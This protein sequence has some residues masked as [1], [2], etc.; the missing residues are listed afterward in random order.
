M[1]E[2]ILA[3]FLLAGTGGGAMIVSGHGTDLKDAITGAVPADIRSAT[4]DVRSYIPSDKPEQ[5]GLDTAAERSDA[6]R[7]RATTMAIGHTD[8]TGVSLR[9]DC[10]DDARIAG[11]LPEGTVVSV[12]ERGSGLCAEWSLVAAE[13]V[14][15]WV[16]NRYLIAM[17]AADPEKNGAGAPDK[18]DSDHADDESKGGEPEDKSDGNRRDEGRANSAIELPGQ[19]AGTDAD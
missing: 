9:S 18:L 1:K 8:G 4:E 10:A 14:S 3:M 12:T 16:R 13:G 11:S 6:G 17:P 5:P 15:T 19:P 7:G 2:L